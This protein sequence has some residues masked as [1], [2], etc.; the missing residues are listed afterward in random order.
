MGEVTPPWRGSPSPSHRGRG[1]NNLCYSV[2]KSQRK[3][4]ASNKWNKRVMNLRV[5]F[6]RMCS[7]LT[8]RHTRRNRRRLREEIARRGVSRLHVGCGLVL[9]D[10]WLNI[11]YER[12]EEYGRVKERGG[13]AGVKL[14]LLQN[15]TLL[16]Q[17]L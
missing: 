8:L 16:Q 6:W 10:G 17:S 7:Y 14:K 15:L 5:A 3:N 12:R 4:M 1:I 9:L 2:V 13:G 11:F